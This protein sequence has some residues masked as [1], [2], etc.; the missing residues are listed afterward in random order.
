MKFSLKDRLLSFRNAFAGIGILVVTQHNFRIHL[1]ATVLV[2]VLGLACGLTVQEWLWMAICIALVVV[3][4]AA[5]TAIECLGNAIT[6]EPNE[7]IRMAK[8]VS[9]AMVLLASIASVAIGFVI[10]APKLWNSL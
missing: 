3:T 9:A 5:N 8:D 7:H 1:A 2:C 4:E 10:L 6:R